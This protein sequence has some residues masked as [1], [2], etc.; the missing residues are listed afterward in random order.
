MQNK[1]TVAAILAVCAILG[2][3]AV[4][5]FLG[6]AKV[7][8]ENRDFF[9]MALVA[10]I[11]FCSTA[12]GYYLGSSV[13]SAQKNEIL[14]AVATPPA[15]E[16]PANN[17]GGFIRLR[18]FAFLLLFTLLYGAILLIGCAST[19]VKESP[20]S[21]GAK[22]L[23]TSRQGIIAAATTVDTL[24]TQRVLQQSQC[25]QARVL[26]GQSQLAW[27]AAADAF[28]LFVQTGD[29]TQYQAALPRLFSLTKDIDAIVAPYR[30][31]GAK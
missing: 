20:Q 22:A 13:G 12:F 6:T 25:D 2:F 21:V 1:N 17:Q 4:F 29:G 28:L 16:P 14:A 31:G 23:L 30:N 15:A 19:S 3:L 5:I 7:P 8:Q 24:C 11:G 18:L 26:Y 10:L 9:N 27:T